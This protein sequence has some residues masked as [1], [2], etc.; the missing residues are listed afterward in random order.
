MA[1]TYSAS[2]IV[3]NRSVNND[4][5]MRVFEALACGSLLAA[6]DLSDNG[7]AELFQDGVHLA[8]YSS[9]E[10]LIDK[11]R[12]YLAHDQARERIAAAGMAEA[13]SKH[14][15][16]QRMT[17]LLS[18]VEQYL[19]HRLIAVAPL[20]AAPASAAASPPQEAAPQEAVAEAAAPP[21][22]RPAAKDPDYFDLARP[23]LLAMVPP[24]ARRVLDV[25]C[26]AGRLGQAVKARQEARVVG[27][28][29]DQTAARAVRQRLDEVIEQDIETLDFDQNAFD[30]IVCGDVLEHLREPGRLLQRARR[31][32][33]R[34]GRLVASIPNIR[35]HSV[36]RSLLQGNWTYEPAGLL[37][38]GHLRLFTRRA[39]Q[40]L[41]AAA[42]YRLWRLEPVPGPGYDQWRQ[43]GRPG[44]VRI[45]GLAITGLP[46]SEAEEF[47]T[48]QY[49]VEAGPVEDPA[50]EPAVSSP[51]PAEAEVRLGCVLAI[52]NRSPERLER[53]LQTY[54]YQSIRAADKVLVDYGSAADLAAQYARLARI[55]GWRLF[56]L[57]PVDPRWS[58]SAAYNYAVSRLAPEVNV[59]F[60]S[61]VDVLL[62]A[63]VL[64]TAANLGR[65]KYC[66]FSCLATAQDAEYPRRFD[67]PEDL[68]RLLAAAPA[69]QPMMGDGIHAYPRTWFE[70]IGGFD[71]QFV[72]WGFQESDLHVRADWTIGSVRAAGSAARPSVA[73]AANLHRGRAAQSSLLRPHEIQPASSAER[74]PAGGRVP[75]FERR[76]RPDRQFLYQE[77]VRSASVAGAVG[78]CGA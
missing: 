63:D 22:V 66:I 72:L 24:E 15:Y 59:V 45:G 35:H 36:V 61:D 60:K 50:A 48:Y 7:Q 5:N 8:A 3:L 71:L 55:Y 19:S 1:R 23:E 75:L 38:D 54:A 16:R 6:N 52:Q 68:D 2:K 25:G 31:W 18:V 67:S 12:F 11:I 13:V 76:G 73:R 17:R 65:D 33:S 42:G 53:A 49:L 40:E 64:E 39:I 70:S 69:P 27:V 21:A 62:G 74:R 4:V 43:S 56:R 41:F 51:S 28:E 37:D 10:E 32:L 47:F 44:D 78:G 46:E 9:A 58:L 77:S 34:Q 26:G 30:C 14:T 29:I 57:A 20:A